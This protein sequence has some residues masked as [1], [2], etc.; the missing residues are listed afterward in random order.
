MSSDRPSNDPGTFHYVRLEITVDTAVITP[1]DHVLGSDLASTTIAF[2]WRVDAPP[3]G[4][5]DERIYDGLAKQMS[6][7]IALIEGTLTVNG[8]VALDPP[9]ER[10]AEDADDTGLTRFTEPVPVHVVD[11][12][13]GAFHD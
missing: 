11:V 9:E 8:W 10:M 6:K 3:P 12:E 4:I 5:S 2:G 1:E 7:V 13:R